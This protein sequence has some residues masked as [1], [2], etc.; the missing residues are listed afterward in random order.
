MNILDKILARIAP[1][2]CIAC[3]NEGRVLCEACLPK[4]G[5]RLASRCFRCAAPTDGFRICERCCLSVP[6]RSVSAAYPYAGYAKQLVKTFKF[7]GKRG[8]AAEIA[9]LVFPL[10]PATHDVILVHVPTATD[11][12]RE[13]GYDHAKLLASE[14]SKLSRLPHLS[15]LARTSQQRQVGSGR[16]DRLKNIAGSFRVIGDVKGAHIILI[17]DV[18]T[19]GATLAEAAKV[20][21]AAGAKQV[22]AIV[23]AQTII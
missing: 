3:G 16:A 5:D 18:V 15:L 23:F 11:R 21:R 8:A 14:I 9:Q 6:L 12:I 4:L 20:L 13:R 17:D 22:D 7:D 19:T 1:Y 2:D 10:L